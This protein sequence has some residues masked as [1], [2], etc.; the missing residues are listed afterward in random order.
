MGAEF[1]R[2]TDDELR[3][4]FCELGFFT[5]SPTLAPLL[6]QAYRAA[7]VSDITVLL[8][9]ETG[10]GKQVLALAI[11]RLDQKRKVFPFLSRCIAVP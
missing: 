5:S 10:T 8:E 6:R 7:F 3:R 4:V 11:H 9:G 1:L 2:V